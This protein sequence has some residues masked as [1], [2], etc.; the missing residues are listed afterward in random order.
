MVEALWG[1]G[2][3]GAW[4]EFDQ[5]RACPPASLRPPFWVVPPLLPSHPPQVQDALRQSGLLPEHMP[6]SDG[7]GPPGTQGW[8]PQKPQWAGAPGVNFDL[9]F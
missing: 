7:Q 9:F 3:G 8:G 4:A 2:L 6:S 1:R 5:E